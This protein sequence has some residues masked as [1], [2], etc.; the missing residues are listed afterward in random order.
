MR[1]L[2]TLVCLAATLATAQAAPPTEASVDALLEASR[3]ERLLEGMYSQI[4]QAMRNGMQQ[5]VQGQALSAEQQRVIDAAPARLAKVLRE[6]LNYATLK[7]M[8]VQI[9]RETFTQDEIDGLLAFYRSPAGAAMVEKMP[10]AMQKSMG[11][12]QQRMGPVMAKLRAA[13]EAAVAEAKATK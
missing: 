2:A 9:Y 7:P 13:M 10:L 11:A 5:A 8:Y 12:V 4:E 6:E 1:R 3:S